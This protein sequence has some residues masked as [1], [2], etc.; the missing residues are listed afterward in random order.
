MSCKRAASQDCPRAVH[1]SVRLSCCVLITNDGVTRGCVEGGCTAS[2]CVINDGVDVT[3][4]VI[5]SHTAA[6]AAAAVI[7]LTAST[8]DQTATVDLTT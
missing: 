2:G 7:D 6:M 8:I 1:I 5:T 3:D 4:E